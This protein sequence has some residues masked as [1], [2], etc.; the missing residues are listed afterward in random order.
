M[1]KILNVY[2]PKGLTP[3]AVVNQV[4]NK[5]PQYQKE[6]IAYAGR[7]D[8][9]AHGV[10]LLMIGEE[11]TKQKDNYLNLPKDYEF[12]VLFGVSTDT[13]DVLGILQNINCHSREG[14]NPEIEIKKFLASKLGKQTQTYP[15]YSSKA[16]NGKPLH[17]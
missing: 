1:K 15:P 14:G 5:F 12:E 7:L 8:P 16:V 17:W 11:T 2:K 4:K 10:L 3:L 6:K 9:L 13:Y